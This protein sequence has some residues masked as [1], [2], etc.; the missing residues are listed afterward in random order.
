MKRN[1]HLS[2]TFTLQKDQAD[3]GIGCLL[4]LIRYYGGNATVESLREKSGTSKQGT[5]L[6]GLYQAANSIGFDAEGCEADIK[7]LV[8]HGEPVILHVIMDEKYE[9]YVVCYYYENNKFCIGDPARGIIYWSKEEL[10]QYWRTKTCLT[11]KPNTDFIKTEYTNKAKKEWLF[12]LLKKD[13]EAIYTIIVLGVVLT[14]LGMSMSIFS[15]KLIDDILPQ[16]KLKVLMLSIAFLGF[17]L[18]AR[19]A[20]QALRDLYIVKQNKSFN[21]RINYSFFSSLLHLPKMFFDTRKIGDFVARLNDTQRIQNVIKQLITATTV[22]ILSVF[23]SL[24]FLFFYSWKL[25]VICLI[26]SPIIFYIIFSFNKRII[27]SQQEVMQAYSQNEANYIDSIR[28]IEVIKNF[29]RQDIF[30]KR[31]QN[32]FGLFQSKIYELGRLNLRI[33]L[34]SGLVLV[35][36]LLLILAFSSYHVLNNN[37]KIGELMAII[38]ISSSLLASITNLALVSIPIQEA[39]VAFDRMFEYSSIKPEAIDGIALDQIN[40]INIQGIDF[41]YNGRS[42]LLEDVSLVL[43]KGKI[44]TL[45]GESGNGKTTLAEILQK[46]YKPEAGNIIINGEYNLEEI[47][48]SSW[49]YLIGIVPQNIQLFNGS[50]AQNIVL[51]EQINEERLNSLVTDFGFAKF[52]SSLPQG[53]GTLV[54]EEGINLSGGQKQLL[55]WMRALYHNPEFLILDEPT[56]SLDKETRSFIYSLISKLK[57]K[58]VIF[59]I[60]HYIEDLHNIS[61]NIIVLRDKTIKSLNKSEISA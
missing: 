50:V 60:S 38:G 56:S 57:S 26:L 23:I 43:E 28:G 7:A 59:I 39:K 40:S 18:F 14:L 47:S 2:K 33:S 10:E 55:G 17:L 20:I 12:N 4:S 25:A 16:R 22:D 31:N 11:L 34:T 19:V 36:F 58:K 37:I 46:N 29:S 27:E 21:E 51:D 32:I 41:R 9:H 44:T 6:L 35:V 30:L 24:G 42:K 49:R 8:E 3:C 54:G 53:W 15:Q 61:D 52:I 48:L 5:T 13:Q 45:L 1:K